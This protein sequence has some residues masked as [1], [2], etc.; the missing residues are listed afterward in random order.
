MSIKDT[1]GAL[2]ADPTAAGIRIVT[3]YQ[4]ASGET[5]TPPAGTLNFVPKT[6]KHAPEDAL[7][8]LADGRRAATIDSWGSQANRFEAAI[9][10]LASQIGYPL[11]SFSDEGG[12][13]ASSLNL[14]H[15]QADGVW[16]TSRDEL[17]AV[18]VPYDAIQA[19]TVASAGAL[20]KWYPSALL[21]GWWHSQT[22][23]SDKAKNGNAVFAE[24]DVRGSLDGTKLAMSDRKA[25]RLVTSEIVAKG[26]NIRQRYA[27]LVNPLFGGVGAG[28]SEAGLSS[29]QPTKGPVDVTFEE[30]EGSTFLSLPLLRRL[31]LG[32]NDV[33][34]KI[35]VLALGLLSI[36]ESDND[37]HL[38]TGTELIPTA[39]SIEAVRPYGEIDELHLDKAEL[40][41]LVTSLGAKVG[42]G[43]HVAARVSPT[44][45]KLIDAAAKAEVSDD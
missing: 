43:G 23:L 44:L 6:G 5:V 15:R 42:W 26:V 38:R 33:D 29:I 9:E 31:G 35:L 4:S 24:R 10:R 22:K 41:G 28:Y 2:I 19:A 30:I 18:G 34:G 3:T 36:L 7:F 37:L 39:R 17:I 27:G 20:L 45:K 21:F 32:D 8:T 1:L 12:A 11:V 25:S 13:R 40:I 16:R 14:S